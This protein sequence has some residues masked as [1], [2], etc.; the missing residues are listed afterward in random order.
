MVASVMWLA[1]A[2]NWLPDLKRLESDRRIQLANALALPV[3]QHVQRQRTPELERLLQAAVERHPEFVSI[4]WRNASGRLVA[5]GGE[6]Q[7]LWHRTSAEEPLPNQVQIEMKAGDAPIG[8]LEFCL[9]VDEASQIWSAYTSYPGPLIYGLSLCCGLLSGW[10]LW[11]AGRR[12]LGADSLA[13]VHSAFDALSE[14]VF[15]VDQNGLVAVHNQAFSDLAGREDALGQDPGRLPW[16]DQDGKTAPAI[17]PWQATLVDGKTRRGV[18][19]GMLNDLGRLKLIRVNCVP[20]HVGRQKPSGVMVSLEDIT[21]AEL[22]RVEMIRVLAEL[23]RSEAQVREKNRRLEQLATSDPLT[24]CPNRRS[25]YDRFQDRCGDAG[26]FPFSVLMMDI[27]HFKRINDSCGHQVG[28][29]VLQQVAAT[30]RT[31]AP[32]KDDVYRIGGEEFAVLLPHVSEQSA[33]EIAHALREAVADQA[34]AGRDVTISVGLVTIDEPMDVEQCLEYAD[35]A[36]YH[37]KR[38]GRNQVTTYRSIADLPDMSMEAT[39]GNV[40]AGSIAAL[41]KTLAYREPSTASHSLRV[42][43]LCVATAEG[44]LT[45]S[46]VGILETAALMHDIG[47][48]GIPDAILLKPTGLTPEEKRIMSEHDMYSREIVRTACGSPEVLEIIETHH[49]F[50]GSDQQRKPSGSNIPIAARIL[51]I[52]D[53][54]DSIVND[55]VYRKAR[56]RAE[57]I[58]ELRR[59]SPEQFDP[60]LVEMFVAKTENLDFESADR[61]DVARRAFAHLDALEKALQLGDLGSVREL[62]GKWN[63]NTDTIEDLASLRDRMDHLVAELDQEEKDWNTLENQTSEIRE[64]CHAAYETLLTYDFC[65]QVDRSLSRLAEMQRHG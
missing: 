49:K 16:L 5:A 11:R 46:E 15:M 42:A 53:A 51:A 59:C 20:V 56:S 17:L 40:S 30:L 26:T 4:G 7:V 13:S 63:K 1:H 39:S 21:I 31:M 8:T 2:L 12:R 36:M 24:Q 55:R 18:V 41:L 19:L 38:H 52:C 57:A 9:S 48:V 61:D 29:H 23:R 32:D 35:R 44:L 27:D 64:I 6:H 25:L 10:W 14:A 50:F 62:A 34:I 54:Y 60:E 45:A 22:Q 43:R 58:K 65:Q 3:S 37:S 33:E 47:K 28:D